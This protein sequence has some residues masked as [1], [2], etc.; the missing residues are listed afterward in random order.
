MP[1]PGSIT[2]W[3]ANRYAGKRCYL[4]GAPAKIIGRLCAQAWIAPLNTALAPVQY[5]WH[6]VQRVMRQAGS[7]R[8]K[9]ATMNC[10]KCIGQVP[11]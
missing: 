8:R 7:L 9:G 5:S 6:T 10:K 4:N 3:I 11:S 1:E 2:Q